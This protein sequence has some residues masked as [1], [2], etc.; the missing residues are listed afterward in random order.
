MIKNN[1]W[2]MIATVALVGALASMIGFFN[3]KNC[4]TAQ[5]EGW[6]SCSAISQQQGFLFWGLLAVSV[7]GFGVSVARRVTKKDR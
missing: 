4:V 7:F 3:S 5:T 6:T 1:S 2:A